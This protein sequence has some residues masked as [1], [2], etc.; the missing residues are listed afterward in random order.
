M[1][2]LN[3]LNVSIKKGIKRLREDYYLNENAGVSDEE[4]DGFDE[5]IK[6]TEFRVKVKPR[7]FLKVKDVPSYIN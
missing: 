2:K 4:E 6:K 5:R 1:L 3:Q 7:R